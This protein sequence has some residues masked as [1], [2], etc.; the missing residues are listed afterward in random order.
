MTVFDK[1]SKGSVLLVT[2]PVPWSDIREHWESYT[3]QVRAQWGDL[4]DEDISAVAGNRQQLVTQIQGRY[5]MSMNAA[6]EEV[7]RWQENVKKFGAP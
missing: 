7:D 5:G 3:E 1:K 2:Q 4:T 6:R